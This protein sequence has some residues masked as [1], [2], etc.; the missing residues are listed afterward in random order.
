MTEWYLVSIMGC[1]LDAIP[2][3]FLLVL[4]VG[5]GKVETMTLIYSRKTTI[6]DRP[7]VYKHVVDGSMRPLAATILH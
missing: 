1:S 5:V 7:K 6:M 4:L 2:F 3:V